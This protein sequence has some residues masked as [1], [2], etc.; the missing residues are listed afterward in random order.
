MKILFAPMRLFKV[1]QVLLLLLAA[2]CSCASERFSSLRRALLETLPTEVVETG[3]KYLVRARLEELRRAIPPNTHRKLEAAD[4]MSANIAAQLHD[5][6]ATGMDHLLNLT[7]KAAEVGVY[8]S[9]GDAPNGEFL[10]IL[11]AAATSINYHESELVKRLG[12]MKAAE[13]DSKDIEKISKLEE[14]LEGLFDLL[15]KTLTN[16]RKVE[17]VV[18][19]GK[20]DGKE[21]GILSKTIEET[22]MQVLKVLDELKGADDELLGLPAADVV[23]VSTRGLLEKESIVNNGQGGR[24]ARKVWNATHMRFVSYQN[25]V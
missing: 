19:A 3:G 6:M 11:D 8:Q 1:S 10:R 21:I 18:L 12:H 24:C 25:V 20:S 5:E 22:Y 23:N 7:A 2:K 15:M 14:D 16:V 13:T 17:L 4:G 9:N